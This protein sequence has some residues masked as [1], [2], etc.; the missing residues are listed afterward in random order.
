MR[1]RTYPGTDITVSEVGFG[2]WTLAAGWWGTFSDEE[3]VALLHRAFDLGITHYD[4]GDTYGNGRADELLHQAFADRW[5]SVTVTTKVGYDFYAH[6]DARRGQQA[7]P[8]NASPAY[9]RTAVERSL[10]RMGRETVDLVSFHNAEME[11]V[12][13]DAI[14]EI[15]QRLQEEG[16]IRAWGAALGPSNGYLYEGL[17]LIRNRGVK[18]LQL[19]DNIL[20][21]FPGKNLTQAAEQSG[22]T[23]IQVR[24]THSSGMLEGKYTEDTEF[25][26]NDHRRHRPAL[27][28]STD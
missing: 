8:H 22:A 13:D 24:V 9:L 7:I 1:Y 25:A 27:G 6:P 18:N 28:S 23:G 10:E 11:H 20:E 26:P 12:S 4:A 14:W 5:N 15:L 17:E 3:A 21:P 19:I 16:K 2:L